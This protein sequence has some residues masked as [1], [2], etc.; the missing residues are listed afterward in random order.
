MA[1]MKRKLT[2]FS[3][4]MV[5]AVSAQGQAYFSFFQLRELVP[6]TQSL[7]PAFMPKNSFTLALPAVNVGAA[8]QAD[9]KLQ[10]LLSKPDNSIDYTVDFDV[11]LTATKETNMMS[12]DVNSNLFYLGLKTKKAGI[13]LFANVRATYD[14][15]YG[16]DLIEFAANGNG[17]RVG[18]TL[19]FSDTRIMFNSFHEIGLGYTRSF[20]GERLTVGGRIKQVTGLFHASLDEN[21]RGTI[22]TDANDYSWTITVENGTAN[23]AGLDLLFN[24]EDYPDDAVQKYATS[25]DNT[26][27]VFDI[28]AKFKVFDWLH[29]E[30]AVN[31]IGSIDWKE[32]ARNYNTEDRAV[33]FT[34]VQ[35]RGLENSGDVFKDSVESKFSSNETQRP[36]TTTLPTRSYLAASLFLGPRNR[37]T[38]MAFRRSIFGESVMSYAAA[39][40]HSV[41]YFTFGLVGGYRASNSEFNVGANLASDIGPLQMYLALDNAV[42]LN[43][44]ERYSK[45]DFRFGLNLMFGYKKW[46]AKSEVVNLDEL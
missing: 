9:F 33:T 30:A 7:Q 24:D 37:F 19:D 36:F 22:T 35:L 44:P 31:D 29:V 14:M 16:R 5:L 10:D 6:Q 8:L 18:G 2:I 27:M 38:A 4:A 23:T 32:Q 1:I 43:R 21:A 20:L 42:V 3:L 25:N 39:Y 45:L 12:L 41:K 26:A 46:K 15:K 40:N 28:G 17:N 11:L 13:S 34:G